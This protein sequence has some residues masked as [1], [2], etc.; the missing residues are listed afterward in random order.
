MPLHER[1]SILHA[2]LTQCRKIDYDEKTR[3]YLTNSSRIALAKGMRNNGNTEEKGG[4]MSGE[5]HEMGKMTTRFA[6]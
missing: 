4:E 3:E 5:C 2:V 6:P 1:A